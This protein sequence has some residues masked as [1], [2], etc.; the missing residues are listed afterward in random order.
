MSPLPRLTTKSSDLLN[1]DA[2]RFIAAFGVMLF[3]SARY[4]DFG[5]SVDLSETLGPLRLLV[6]LFFAISGFVIGYSYLERASDWPSVRRFLLGRF[7]YI[8]PIHFATFVFAVAMGIVGA[9]KSEHAE[10]FAA[11]CIPANLVLGQAW[12]MCGHLSF[13]MPSWSLSAEAM[14]YLLFPLFVMVARRKAFV[15]PMASLAS[16]AVLTWA[17]WGNSSPWYEWTAP[18][19]ALRAL[20]SF[21]FG[22]SLWLYRDKVRNVAGAHGLLYAFAVGVI[23]LIAAHAPYLAILIGVYG[24]VIFACACDLQGRH[25]NLVLRL[26]PLGSLTLEIY[27]IHQLALTVFIAVAAKRFLGLHGAAMN[28]A[29]L[30]TYVLVFLL[31]YAAKFTFVDPLKR[32][33]MARSSR[34]NTLAAVVP[35]RMA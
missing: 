2:L 35:S 23:A 32:S 17:S 22:L 4:F 30:L 11:A 21:L 10:N 3:H 27:M 8:Y 7:A 16:F 19:G 20:P 14:M 28:A 1:I 26:A 25:S 9:G 12:G 18:S 29:V 13:N 5:P 34:S 31:A 6:D 33:I 24:V 15:I